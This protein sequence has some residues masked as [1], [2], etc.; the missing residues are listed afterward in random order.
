[1]SKMDYNV[2]NDYSHDLNHLISDIL[3]E[4]IALKYWYP[5]NVENYYKTKPFYEGLI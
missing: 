3:L 4:D 5:C 2:N 1:M